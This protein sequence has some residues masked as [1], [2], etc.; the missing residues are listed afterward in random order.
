[1]VPA[2]SSGTLT[3]V[4]LHWNAMLQT[5]GIHPTLLQYTVYR[6][7][8]DLLLRYPLMWNITLEYTTS[9]Q[10]LGS[11]PTRKSFPDLS[12]TI[13][14]AQLYNAVMMVVSQKLSRR[15]SVPAES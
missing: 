15:C 1:M 12:Q 4:M 8:A 10:C 5:Q 11:D 9:N 13:A 6:H 2:C 7:R 3:K 14:N